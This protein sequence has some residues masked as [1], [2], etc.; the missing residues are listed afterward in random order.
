M[1]VQKQKWIL[2]LTLAKQNY[3]YNN[4]KMSLMEVGVPEVEFYR[5]A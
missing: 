5:Q 4:D 2:F 3:K 1:I